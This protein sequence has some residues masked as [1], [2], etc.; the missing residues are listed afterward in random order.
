MGGI[1]LASSS[2]GNVIGY[3]DIHSAEYG[4]KVEPGDTTVQRLT[5]MSSSLQ[6]FTGNALELNASRASVENT[7]IANAQ[8][9][10]VKV[11]GGDVTFV[12]CTIANFYVWRQRD[13]A[14]ALHNSIDGAPAPLNRAL[15]AN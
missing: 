4:I 1:I 3:C 9:N 13:V 7:L 5:I 10:C 15:F 6:N 2:N 14:L 11:V 12:H 8:G